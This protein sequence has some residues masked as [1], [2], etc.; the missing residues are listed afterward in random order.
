MFISWQADI[1]ICSND[2]IHSRLSVSI[3]KT[4]KNTIPSYKTYRL[5]QIS[6]QNIKYSYNYQ[7][8]AILQF[9]INYKQR[10]IQQN[11]EESISY[12]KNSNIWSLRAQYSLFLKF[13]KKK[14]SFFCF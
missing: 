2:T 13:I 7:Q 4:F 11:K 12:S 10:Y 14:L 1:T 3:K 8:E 6:F 9:K 5:Y